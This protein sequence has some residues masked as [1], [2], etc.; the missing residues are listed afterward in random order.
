MD[1]THFIITGTICSDAVYSKGEW[2]VNKD[3]EGPGPTGQKVNL[4]DVTIL[5]DYGWK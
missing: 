3:F 1:K 5:E 2:G 4:F